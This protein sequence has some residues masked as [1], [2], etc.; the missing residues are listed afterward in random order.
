MDDK[1]KKIKAAIDEAAKTNTLFT[2]TPDDIKTLQDAGHPIKEKFT[3]Y[4]EYIDKLYSQNKP[5]GLQLLQQM[6]LLDKSIANNVVTFQYEDLRASVASVN[7]TSI[8]I[9]SILLLEYV[10]ADP[11]KMLKIALYNFQPQILCTC[12]SQLQE[13]R[14]H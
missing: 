6:P 4:E 13:I 8:T 5:L 11:T 10:C 7:A 14:L 1:A 9:D 12:E 2:A 3:S